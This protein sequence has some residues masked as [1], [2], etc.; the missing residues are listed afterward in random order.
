M[1]MERVKPFM[2]ALQDDA[3]LNPAYVFENLCYPLEDYFAINGDGLLSVCIKV[4][5]KKGRHKIVTYDHVTRE[6]KPL[7]SIPRHKFERDVDDGVV[8]VNGPAYTEGVLGSLTDDAQFVVILSHS[9]GLRVLSVFDIVNA[10]CLLEKNCSKVDFLN[11]G[12]CG[13][14]IDRDAITRGRFKIAILN[15]EMEV[16][17]WDATTPAESAVKLEGGSPSFNMTKHLICPRESAVKFSTDG[18]FLCVLVGY[19][20]EDHYRHHCACIVMDPFE[21]EPLYAMEYPFMY[22]PM[23]SIFPA[24]STCGSKLAMFACSHPNRVVDAD[25]YKLLF[26]EIPLRVETLKR[27]CRSSILKLVNNSSLNKL[28]L[29]ENLIAYL[30]DNC[31]LA[32]GSSENDDAKRCRLM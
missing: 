13:I 14:S 4:N 15:L 28:P 23:S 5:D 16:R 1:F 19:Y 11:C 30:Q 21:L 29:S 25:D 6:L 10:T 12:P 26:F 32:R 2:K 9:K 3:V 8:C 18:R 22:Q 7:G 24:F 31:I 27:M 17:V 20:G